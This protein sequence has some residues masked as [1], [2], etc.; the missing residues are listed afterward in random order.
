M[1]F[2]QESYGRGLSEV[3][4]SIHGHNSKIHD[5]VVG[6]KGAF[7]KLTDAITNCKALGMRVRLNYVITDLSCKDEDEY[8]YLFNLLDP[9]EINFL[10]LNRFTEATQYL[11]Y[12][13]STDHI[14]TIIDGIDVNY[15]NVRYTPY[16]YMEG[17]EEYVCNTFQH[18]YDIYDWNMAVYDQRIDPKEYKKDPLDALY[19]QAQSD[20]ENM[21]YKPDEC[22]GCKHFLICDGLENGVEDKVWPW[23][24]DL[25]KE[26]NHYRKGYY[27]K[28]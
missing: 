17:Y 12:D 23:E 9:F 2:V 6:R 4:F 28:V 13:Q 21:Y 16:C 24:G 1:D 3:M 10:T 25:I 8:I 14:K 5:E 18:I 11:S 22:R 20:R 19:R 26:I 7:R 27:A 15:I